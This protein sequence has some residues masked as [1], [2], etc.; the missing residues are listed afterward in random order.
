[1]IM[2]LGEPPPACAEA[3][4]S[5]TLYASKTH[6]LITSLRLSQTPGE[7]SEQVVIAG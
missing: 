6:L 2:T 7:V 4:L 1:M 5:L 3:N